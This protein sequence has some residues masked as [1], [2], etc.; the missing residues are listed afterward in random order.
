VR[1]GEKFYP[2]FIDEDGVQRFEQNSVLCHLFQTGKLDLN[3]LAVDYHEKKFSKVDYA[4]LNMMLGYSVSGFCD[5]SSFQDMRI[6]NPLW[7]KKK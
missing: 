4:E 2:T 5:L 7:R 1:V 3:Q 6:T